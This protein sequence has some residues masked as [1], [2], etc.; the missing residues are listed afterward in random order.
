MFIP[1]KQLDSKASYSTDSMNFNLFLST[2]SSFLEKFTF[3]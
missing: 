1:N 2:I 3:M